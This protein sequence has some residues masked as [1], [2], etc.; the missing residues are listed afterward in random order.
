MRAAVAIAAL[1][2]FAAANAQ[3]WHLSAAVPLGSGPR[4]TA[5]EA[6]AAAPPK[7][8][9]AGDEAHRLPRRDSRRAVPQATSVASPRAWAS[10]SSDDAPRAPERWPTLTAPTPTAAPPPPAVVEVA[11]APAPPPV[12]PPV[13]PVPPA[14]P[15]PPPVQPAPPPLLGTPAPVPPAPHADPA[16]ARVSEAAPS[17]PVAVRIGRVG[18][19]APL[20]RLGLLPGGALEVPTSFSDAGWY[21]GGPRPGEVGPAVVA[22]HVANRRGPGAFFHL[23]EVLPGDVV[24]V[25]RADG[26]TLRFVVERV[27][28]AP[29]A[30][31]PTAEVYG[32]T[33]ERALRLITCG[34]AF[35]AAW[36]H[37][38]DNVIVFAT[39]A[40][41]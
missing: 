3:L 14:E 5:A 30:A 27:V 26:T 12:P 32:P 22:A 7:P 4:I 19:A 40:A 9:V 29:K 21:V 17:D 37:Y 31:F 2:V 35:D 1:A 38:L 11:A 28:Q 16:A 6:A 10:V 33:S 39:A 18:I 13:P 41:D 20:I 34:G 23:K 25:D 15:T 24:E 36:G 8:S